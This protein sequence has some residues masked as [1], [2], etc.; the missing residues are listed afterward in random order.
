MSWTIKQNTKLDLIEIIFSGPITG[1]DLRQATSDCISQAKEMGTMNYLIDASAMEL[2]GSIADLYDLPNKQYK[3]E[4]VDR[5]SRAAVILPLSQKERDNIRFYETACKNQGWQVQ[6]FS[7]R[8]EAVAWLRGKS[9]HLPD[10]GA[11]SR[12]R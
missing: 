2:S 10:T 11:G 5:R 1:P 4:G 3:E 12:H 9:S 8:Q 7:E 6:V